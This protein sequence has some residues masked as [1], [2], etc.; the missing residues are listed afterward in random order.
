MR[1]GWV[2]LGEQCVCTLISEVLYA[3]MTDARQCVIS[4]GQMQALAKSCSYGGHQPASL[5]LAN[6]CLLVSYSTLARCYRRAHPIRDRFYS[7]GEPLSYCDS[8]ALGCCSDSPHSTDLRCTAAVRRE[9]S[10]YAPPRRRRRTARH[11][12]VAPRAA[13]EAT[14]QFHQPH[15]W[16]RGAPRA[17]PQHAGLPHPIIQM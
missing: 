16:Y 8:A 10:S 15:Q 6:G 7:P 3:R 11:K 13:G 17:G 1:R 2:K 14:N 12:R 4:N 5:R 9:H